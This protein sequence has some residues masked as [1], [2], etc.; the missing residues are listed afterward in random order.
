MWL[1]RWPRYFSPVCQSAELVPAWAIP[2]RSIHHYQESWF[3]WWSKQSYVEGEN[4]HFKNLK[5]STSSYSVA[6]FL[7]LTTSILLL[8]SYHYQ[9]ETETETLSTESAEKSLS[10]P[11]ISYF[12]LQQVLLLLSWNLLFKSEVTF[13][14][15]STYWELWS[16]SQFFPCFFSSDIFLKLLSWY[17]CRWEDTSF[18]FCLKAVI[19]LIMS[20]M[21]FSFPCRSKFSSFSIAMQSTK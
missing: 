18:N 6:S 1:A 19:A 5:I 16:W 17:C 3:R 13:F 4:Y 7:P 12:M 2:V 20:T 8:L 14:S 11:S 9:G 21:D 15:Q 10:H